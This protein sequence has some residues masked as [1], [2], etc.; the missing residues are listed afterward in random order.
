MPKLI[1]SCAINGSIC[2]NNKHP[3]LL[4]VF[5]DIPQCM[6]RKIILIRNSNPHNFL[7]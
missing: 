4:D 1:R 7:F 5:R 3:D 6:P 2:I